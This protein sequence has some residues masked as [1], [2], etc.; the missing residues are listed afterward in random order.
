MRRKV[1]VKTLLQRI[2]NKKKLAEGKFI[3][4]INY[5]DFD[6]ILDIE[7]RTF[8]P[9]RYDELMAKANHM[10]YGARDIDQL[11]YLK[12]ILPLSEIDRADN[13]PGRIKE[14]TALSHHIWVTDMNK[15]PRDIVIYKSGKF[16]GNQYHQSR[17][18]ADIDQE[19]SFT[20]SLFNVSNGAKKSNLPLS[21][22]N[23]HHIIWTNYSREDLI[24]HPELKDLRKICK[25]DKSKIDLP[26]FIVLNI[27]EVMNAKDINDIK[28]Q[29]NPGQK[30]PSS[31]LKGLDETKK[32][33]LSVRN[34]LDDMKE[35][36]MF[37]SMSDV[38]RIIFAKDIGGMYFDI[39]Q[40]IFD[41]DKVH[42]EQRK[43]NLFD[44]M[45]NYDCLLGKE[46][47]DFCTNCFISSPKSGSPIM[48]EF[49]MMILRNICRPDDVGY[50]KYTAN[51]WSKVIAQTGPS[52][53]SLAF[54]KE[55]L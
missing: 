48:K 21:E 19:N 28:N 52:A 30:L 17:D 4:A 31:L 55:S 35:K 3:K 9:D 26:N 50:I 39:D 32:D 11:D 34:Q 6:R 49:W 22:D 5:T 43:Y 15:T 27:E 45:K 40:T 2:E 24:A 13:T 14:Y 8:N 44:L 42:T 16:I 36:K 37:A 41:Q 10:I 1:T 18:R 46:F 25:I 47:Y 7:L 38:M 33:L 12:S 51:W 29:A 20:E 53:I 54:I 23:F